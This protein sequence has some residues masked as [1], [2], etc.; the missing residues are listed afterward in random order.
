MA[1]LDRNR[2]KGSVNNIVNDMAKTEGLFPEQYC[3][4]QCKNARL[5]LG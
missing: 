4:V 2:E 1:G 5:V 3:A